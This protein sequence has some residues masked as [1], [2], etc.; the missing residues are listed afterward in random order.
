MSLS[1]LEYYA[2][3]QYIANKD[4][5]TKTNPHKRLIRGH[6]I[7]YNLLCK[8]AA[9]SYKVP[10]VHPRVQCIWEKI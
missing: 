8:S 9:G 4:S 7:N 1:P 3:H 2:R 6:F 10:A 5:L